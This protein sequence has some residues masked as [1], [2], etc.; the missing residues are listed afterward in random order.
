MVLLSIIIIIV[1]IQVTVGDWV[2]RK[3]LW[4]KRYE[5]TEKWRTLPDERL[6]WEDNMKLELQEVC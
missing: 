3:M 4:P 2:L 1:L 5:V 6:K